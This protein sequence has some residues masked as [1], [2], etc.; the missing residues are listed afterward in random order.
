MFTQL[1]DELDCLKIWSTEILESA[2][3]DF[4][5]RIEWKAR[6]FFM[7]VRVAITGSKVSPPLFESMEVLGKPLCQQRL[8]D[9]V[10]KLKSLG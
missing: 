6:L 4:G 8:R 3:R 10:Q 9:A 5:E 1:A 7:P 2:L